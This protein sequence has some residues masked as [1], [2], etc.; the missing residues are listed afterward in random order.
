[1]IQYALANPGYTMIIVLFTVSI[2]L[3]TID[4]IFSYFSK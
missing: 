4:H 3:Y 1:M 2:T